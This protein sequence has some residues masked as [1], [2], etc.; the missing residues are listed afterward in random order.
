MAA[1]DEIG[2][3]LRSGAK[4]LFERARLSR[5]RGSRQAFSRARPC[6]TA[7]EFGDR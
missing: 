3:V 4:G 2:V 6:A 1:A 7:I 5:C